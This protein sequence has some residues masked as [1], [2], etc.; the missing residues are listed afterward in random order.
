[1]ILGIIPQMSTCRDAASRVLRLARLSGRSFEHDG[2]TRIT[3]VGDIS[4]SNCNF[5]YPSAPHQLV[6]KEININI[7][8]GSC[9]ALVGSSGSGKSTIASLLLKLYTTPETPLRTVPMIALS[10]RDIKHV[11]TAT[12]RNLITIVSQTPFLFPASI[13][14]NIAYGLRK[15]SQY[16]TPEAIRAAASSA[17]IH[18]F[19]MS[20][21][22]GYDTL[23]GEGGTGLSGGQAQRICIARA[24]IRK[25]SV[26]ILDEATSA[27]D[28]Q[29]AA[30]VR[31]TVRRL[32]DA[33]DDPDPTRVRSGATAESAWTRLT[34]GEGRERLTVIIITHAKEMM[35]V[36]DTIV[37]LDKGRVVEEGGYADLIRKRGPFFKLINGE[38]WARESKAVQRR[39][40]LLMDKVAGV[41]PRGWS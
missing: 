34:A 12:L 2:T 13:A 31:D 40:L 18:D 39:S 38:E 26:L 30:I 10:G 19:I 23:V 22:D 20:L 8:P 3:T 36:A 5:A 27:L 21:P 17:G 14:E 32:V 33:N 9:V 41:S 6:L 1:M 28:P 11:H 15:G 29:S 35:S 7:S 25:P 37:M 24:L 16:S 4:F